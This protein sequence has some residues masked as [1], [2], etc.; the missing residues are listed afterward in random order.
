MTKFTI[1][2]EYM[3]GIKI[4]LTTYST[5]FVLS[6]G[7]ESELVQ[8]CQ[9]LNQEGVKADIYGIGSLPLM[10]YDFVFHFSVHGD[11]LSI[12]NEAV[13]RKKPIYIWPN[14]WWLVPPSPEEI[15][16]VLDF[17]SVA[18]KLIFKSNAELVN[19]TQYIPI[20]KEKALVIPISFSNKFLGESNGELGSLVLNE[21]SSENNR[22]IL[23]MGLIEPIK[24]QLELIRAL[25][26]IP[27]QGVFIGGYR[28]STYYKECV[29]LA[30]GKMKFLPY[31]QPCSD[32][33][34]SLIHNSVGIAEISFDPPGRSVIE[35][36]VMKKPILLLDDV[37]QRE[38]F[39]V[40]AWYAK[41]SNAND[42]AAEL[43]GMLNDAELMRDKIEYNYQKFTSD[44]SSSVIVKRILEELFA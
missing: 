9:M 27:M 32:L 31:L 42:I 18:E 39:G 41:S 40:H 29:D 12:I 36:A 23:C 38:Y 25:K 17:I 28:D 37:W 3:A 16:R 10:N 7:G 2:G 24:N 19:F 5:A 44:N 14:V 15:N 4:L 43:V 26:M 1:Q 6:G 13:L 8:V 11:G 22:Y 35:G 34:I 33:L 21:T 30:E 20:P